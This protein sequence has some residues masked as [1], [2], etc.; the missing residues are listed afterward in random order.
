MFN[1]LAALRSTSFEEIVGML[2]I[3]AKSLLFRLVCELP[4]SEMLVILEALALALA[5]AGDFPQ[6]G[7]RLQTFLVLVQYE[8]DLRPGSISASI[9]KKS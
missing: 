1:M 6:C 2:G 8:H 7:F 9:G 4:S 3:S 5:R